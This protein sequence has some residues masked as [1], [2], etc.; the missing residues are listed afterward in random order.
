MPGLVC[1]AL[2]LIGARIVHTIHC[3]RLFWKLGWVERSIFTVLNHGMVICAVDVKVRAC[4]FRCQ[5]GNGMG[6]MVLVID[7]KYLAR[8]NM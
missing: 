5:V 7:R 3:L 8:M 1:V 6:E 2:H 4:T